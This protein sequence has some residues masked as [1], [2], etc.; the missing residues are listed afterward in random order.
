[1][2]FF[3]DGPEVIPTTSAK[4]NQSKQRHLLATVGVNMIYLSKDE[5]GVK[6]APPPPPS[7]KKKRLGI[8]G[9]NYNPPP[10]PPSKIPAVSKKKKKKKNVPAEYSSI[11]L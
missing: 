5:Y 2:G 6:S 11:R 4:T 8:Y 1:M 3:E 9:I 7:K 10:P